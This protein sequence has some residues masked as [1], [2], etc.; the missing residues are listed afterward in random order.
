M[1]STENFTQCSALPKWE[2]N[3][4]ED[5][6]VYMCVYICVCVCEREREIHFAIYLMAHGSVDKDSAWNA[7]D[8]GDA[9]L[10]P[11]LE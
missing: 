8:K 9:G 4:K 1:Y 3:L 7:G 2:K 6:C 10:I 11:R 5:T